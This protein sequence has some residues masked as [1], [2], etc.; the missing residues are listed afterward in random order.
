MCRPL[1]VPAGA[2]ALSYS[3][4]LMERI[5]VGG[6]NTILEICTCWDVQAQSDFQVHFFF[7]CF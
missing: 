4:G 7:A 6:E 3:P 5:V 2:A 1:L